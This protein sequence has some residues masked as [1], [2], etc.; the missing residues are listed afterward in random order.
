[1]LCG[2][3]V[4]D[5]LHLNYQPIV[6]VK[7]GRVR[8]LECLARWQHRTLGII[9]PATFIPLAEQHVTSCP[10]PM[11][12]VACCH[13]GMR[14]RGEGR[15]ELAVNV[16]A[17]QLKDKSFLPHLDNACRTAACRL[18]CWSSSSRNPRWRAT[19]N[20]CA[21]SSGDPPDESAHCGGRFWY[22]LLLVVL[23]ESSAIDV[24]KV[25]QAFVRDFQHGGATIIK[26][27]WASPVTSAM[28]SSSKGSRRRKC[29]SRCRIWAPR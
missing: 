17:K 27:P 26:Q 8:A 20:N 5:E 11:G 21:R 13:E 23:F 3:L 1:M 24:I 25:D 18:N 22:R 16:S 28:R 10:W 19:W 14:I 2:A 29:S 12:P 15:V 9:S 6:D 7:E 4:Q